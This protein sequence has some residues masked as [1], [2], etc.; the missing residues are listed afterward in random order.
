M[1]IP[2][3]DFCKEFKLPKAK[4]MLEESFL[5]MTKTEE[6][7][8][9]KKLGIDLQME[10]FKKDPKSFF[11]VDKEQAAQLS[12]AFVVDN[13]QVVSEYRKDHDH[14]RFDFARIV[15][16]PDSFGIQIHHSIF[17]CDII[18]RKKAI[19]KI[20]TLEDDKEE[21][22]KESFIIQPIG[23]ENTSP[24]FAMNISNSKKSKN[25]S[26]SCFVPNVKEIE[27]KPVSLDD[28]L[29]DSGYRNFFKTHLAR[30]FGTE[31]IIF[32]EEVQYYKQLNETERKSR[33]D[34]MIEI[35]FDASSFYEINTSL[36]LKKTVLEN[37]ESA[38]KELFDEI[39]DDC[40]NSI[41]QDSFKR[42][43]QSEM[44]QQMFEQ[45]KKKSNF[46]LY[47]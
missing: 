23:S 16:D 4:S 29:K 27:M 19:S 40:L 21:D 17:Q 18:S 13:F 42:F 36:A 20:K 9:L 1:R 11:G 6:R 14:E 32:Y 24:K 22:T 45:E 34:K 3:G 25:F 35:F 26:P 43:Q 47:K 38:S 2:Q 39:L 8:R 30:E 5:F 12:A 37:K 31:T 15:I 28:V 46:L 33:V 7:K 41:R 44:F 10:Y